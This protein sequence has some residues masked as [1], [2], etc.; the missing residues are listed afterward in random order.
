M[1][2]N[3]FKKTEE[4][5]VDPAAEAQRV[6]CLNLVFAT[7][8]VPRLHCDMG[9]GREGDCLIYLKK[10]EQCRFRDPK[11]IP[12]SKEAIEE[13]VAVKIHDRLYKQSCLDVDLCPDCGHDLD[14]MYD[15][16]HGMDDG[17][18]PICQKTWTI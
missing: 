9:D 14:I 4:V 10:A 1:F 8:Q 18:C 16:D 17:K 5:V 7:T 6:N 13:K 3:L 2:G 15:D 11:Y 12:L